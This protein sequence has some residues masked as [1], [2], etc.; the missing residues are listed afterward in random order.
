[1]KIIVDNGLTSDVLGCIEWFDCGASY[2]VKPANG[3]RKEVTIQ[4]IND[5]SNLV[6]FFNKGRKAYM[7]KEANGTYTVLPK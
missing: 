4:S 2:S 5:I 3:G 7:T 6:D 1:M